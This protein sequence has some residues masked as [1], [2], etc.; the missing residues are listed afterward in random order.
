M[1][2]RGQV[3]SLADAEWDVILR[4][5]ETLHDDIK[6]NGHKTKKLKVKL[7]IIKIIMEGKIRELKEKNSIEASFFIATFKT[8]KNTEKDFDKHGINEREFIQFLKVLMNK[9]GKQRLLAKKPLDMIGEFGKM[10]GVVENGYK[11]L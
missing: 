10:K 4:G 1:Q 11:A 6:E 5:M 9:L 3:A 2:S 7:G 8:I